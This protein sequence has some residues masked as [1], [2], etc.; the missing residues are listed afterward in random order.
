M[1]PAKVVTPAILKLSKFVCPSTSKSLGILTPVEFT[2]ILSAV[3]V[4]SVIFNM[5]LF[6]L[7][8]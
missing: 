5:P 1:F 7:I 4:E 6:K 2:T 8:V 3:L